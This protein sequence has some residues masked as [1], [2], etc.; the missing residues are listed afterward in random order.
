MH[1]C[2][3]NSSGMAEAPLHVVVASLEDAEKRIN[4]FEVETVTSFTVF[5]RNKGFREVFSGKCLVM[6]TMFNI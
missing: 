5:R 2:S 1:T 3:V 4:E 6:L